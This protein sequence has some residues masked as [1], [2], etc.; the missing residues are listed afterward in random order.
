MNHD[1]EVLQLNAD[2]TIICQCACG[3][4]SGQKDPNARWS[5]KPNGDGTATVSP[6]IDWSSSGHFHKTFSQAPLG[7][8]DFAKYEAS[9]AWDIDHPGHA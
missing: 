8:V 9:P 4:V 5:V 1:L 3:A 6:S 2:G 7:S